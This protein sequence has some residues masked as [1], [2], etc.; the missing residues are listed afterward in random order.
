MLHVRIAQSE[1]TL[2]NAA[3][4]DGSRSAGG[5]ASTLSLPSNHSGT[6]SG[7]GNEHAIGSRKHGSQ[8]ASN[9]DGS[10]SNGG[11][12]GASPAVG[13]GLGAAGA[14]AAGTVI[15][16]AL[17]RVSVQDQGPGIPLAQQGKIFNV[18]EQVQS[19]RIQQGRG[20]GLGLQ[21]SRSIIELHGGRIGFVSEG[22]AGRGTNFYFD[23]QL[24]IV[25]VDTHEEDDEEAEAARG[26]E[27]S[28]VGRGGDAMA[29]GQPIDDD[30]VLAPRIHDRSNTTAT[31]AALRLQMLE[32]GAANG[33]GGQRL[34]SGSRRRSSRSKESSEVPSVHFHEADFNRQWERSS[35]SHTLFEVSQ[36]PSGSF[37]LP[38]LLAPLSAHSRG[39]RLRRAAPRRRPRRFWRRRACCRRRSPGGGLSGAAGLTLRG[40][41]RAAA[42]D[43]WVA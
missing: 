33:H 1:L 7:N 20:T 42:S 36:R 4:P 43:A 37:A 3:A 12:G 2:L 14:A 6:G 27:A 40:A 9:T 34:S 26:A 29:A 10:S 38:V 32:R 23:I 30:E 19:A 25:L 39:R 41:P 28:L 15:G 35:C 21:I 8:H 5:G 18:Y 13:A 11:R 22:V 16:Q 24:P 31:A 17:F